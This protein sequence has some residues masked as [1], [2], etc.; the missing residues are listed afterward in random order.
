VRVRDALGYVDIGPIDTVAPSPDLSQI[1]GRTLALLEAPPEPA[2]Q[3]T[4]RSESDT[5]S[6]SRREREIAVLI[7]RGLTNR[8]IAAQLFIAERT[9]E[10]HVSN[11]LGKLGLETRAQIAAWA[12]ARGLVQTQR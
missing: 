4:A 1:V 2:T 6:L 7:A 11:I 5:Q 12:V 9:A 3:Q 10:T 8:A